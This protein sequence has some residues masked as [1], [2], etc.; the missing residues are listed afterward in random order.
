MSV[1]HWSKGS[2]EDGI[3]YGHC[4]PRANYSC[5]AGLDVYAAHTP[6]CMRRVCQIHAGH[7]VLACS[8]LQ[9]SSLG[10]LGG[11]SGGSAWQLGGQGCCHGSPWRPC[12]RD[13]HP[14]WGPGPGVYRRHVGQHAYVHVRASVGSCWW[15]ATWLMFTGVQAMYSTCQHNYICTTVLIHSLNKCV[16]VY[17]YIRMLWINCSNGKLF[18]YYAKSWH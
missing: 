9:H 4:T 2:R 17:T 15:T 1:R 12:M 8:A 7:A 6:C 5:N 18:V 13:Q 14:K 11:S 16:G 10:A 3:R